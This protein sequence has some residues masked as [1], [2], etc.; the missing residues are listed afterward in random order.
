MINDNEDKFFH[1]FLPLWSLILFS[2]AI[3]FLIIFLIGLIC[4]LAGCRKSRENP[5]ENLHL[6]VMERPLLG[7]NNQLITNSIETEDPLF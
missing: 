4:H 7:Q 2:I 6:S 3:L 5:T 1:G